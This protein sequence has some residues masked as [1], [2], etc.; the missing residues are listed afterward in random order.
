MLWSVTST[1]IDN[2]AVTLLN[3]WL[4][5]KPVDPNGMHL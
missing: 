2:V 5:G 4:P 1:D 3:H